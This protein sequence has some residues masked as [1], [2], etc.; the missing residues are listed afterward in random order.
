MFG[1]QAFATQPWVSRLGWTLIHFLWQ[2]TVIAAVYAFVRA[3]FMRSSRPNLRY[4]LGCAALVA[5]LAAPL[6]TW[7]LGGGSEP[8]ALPTSA[9]A[10]SSGAALAVIA[11]PDFTPLG[12]RYSQIAPW[13]VAMWLTGAMVFWVRLAGG[14]L[15]AARMR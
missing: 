12:S 3:Y 4:L 15:A 1:I 5:M 13:V 2:G 10:R 6:L 9:V 14:W 7:S 11:S 8:A